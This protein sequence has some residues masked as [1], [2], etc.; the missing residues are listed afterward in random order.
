MQEVW[1]Q[2]PLAGLRARDV[3]LVTDF[4]GTL[5]EIVSDPAQARIVPES[6]EALGLLAQRLRMVAVLS[7]RSLDDLQTRV[8]LPRVQLIGDSGLGLVTADERERL[9]R[10]NLEGGRLLNRYPGVWLEMKTGATAV[11]HRHSSASRD[12]L[13]AT[14]QPAVDATGLRLQPGRRVIEVIPRDHAK[15]DAL[16]ALISERQPLGVVCI[17]DDEND[18]PMFQLVAGLL[19]PH[20]TVGVTS[21][22]VPED[23][24]AGCDL[25]LSDPHEV[26]QF[27]AMLA[28]W[29]AA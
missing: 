29:S 23:L 5:S 17:G 21:A 13:M 15:G 10:F 25:V 11:H 6:L 4:D 12:E 3:I 9:D 16:E 14:L 1:R 19:I 27:L 18:R 2:S 20:L 26:S 24:F 28:D 22:E 7:S 8:P